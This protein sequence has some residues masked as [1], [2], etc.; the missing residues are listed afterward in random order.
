[1]Q[2]LSSVWALLRAARVNAAVMGGVAVSAWR[3]IRAT[4]DV[5]LLVAIDDNQLVDVLRELA[6]GGFHCRRLSPILTIGNT[7]IIQLLHDVPDIALE[8]RV[9]LLLADTDFEKQALTRATEFPLEDVASPILVVACE[10]LIIFKL[11]AGRILD[12]ADVAYLLRANKNRIDLA[13]LQHWSR[14]LELTGELEQ[15][16]K[17]AFPDEQPPFTASPE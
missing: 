9:D 16:W 11:L 17:E 10:D 15:M 2:V 3:H 4:H 13:H 14:K 12:R 1:M 6:R 5:D 7:R 8:I